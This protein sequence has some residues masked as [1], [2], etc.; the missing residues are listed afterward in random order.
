MRWDCSDE[1][2][3]KGYREAARACHPDRAGPGADRQM[4]QRLQAAYEYLSKPKNR[5][6]YDFGEDMGESVELYYNPYPKF[7]PFKKNNR[8]FEMNETLL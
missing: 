3:T 2:L 4:F 8:Y 6:L 7:Q 1:E 5:Q